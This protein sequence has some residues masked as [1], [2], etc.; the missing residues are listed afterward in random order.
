MIGF[1]IIH[2]VQRKTTTLH[3]TVASLHACGSHRLSVYPDDG[4]LGPSR[5]LIRALQDLVH[6][7]FSHV[8]VVDDDLVFC[9]RM[10]PIVNEGLSYFPGAALSLWTIEQNIPHDLRDRPGWLPVMPHE[11]LWGGSVVMD[12]GTAIG[13]LDAMRALLRE[14]VNE[15]LLNKPDALLFLAMQRQKTPLYF[16]LPSL[17][18]HIGTEESTIGNEHG[19][20]ATRGF[21]FSQWT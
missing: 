8:C 2:A 19:D 1:G 9:P 21:K 12:Q 10:L 4:I 18:D 14:K 17:A 20:G 7:P 16:H 3:R 6:G 11:H 13:V 15:P 5:N